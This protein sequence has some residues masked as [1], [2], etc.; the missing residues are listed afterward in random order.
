MGLFD[1]F[2]YTNVHELNLDWVLSMMKALEAEWEAFTAGNSLT[3][4]DPMLH[5]ITKTY[6]KNTIVLDNN[7]NAYVSLQPV[8]VGVALGNQDY[9]LMVFDYEAFI[10][11]VNKNFTAKY[12]RGQYR[13]TAAMAIGDWLTVDDVLC[14]ATAA[15]AADDVL[16]VGVNIEHFTLEDFIKAFMTSANQMIQQYKNDIDASELAYRNQLA[17]DI[18]NT[19]ASLQAQ[20]DAAISG[21]TVDSE[22]INARVGNDH[23]TYPTLGDAIRTQINNLQNA[24]INNMIDIVN[25]EGLGVS[26]YAFVIGMYDPTTATINHAYDSRVT[27]TVPISFDHD[28]RLYIPTGFRCY[29]FKIVGGSITPYGSWTGSNTYFTIPANDE[30]YIYIS[31]NPEDTSETADIT[32]WTEGFK[33][34]GFELDFMH[35]VFEICDF[36][37]VENGAWTYGN[38]TTNA[39]RIRLAQYITVSKGDRIIYCVGNLRCAFCYMTSISDNTWTVENVSGV[40]V[41]CPP[42]NGVVVANIRNDTDTAITVADWNGLIINT[43]ALSKLMLNLSKNGK[44]NALVPNIVDGKNLYIY[45]WGGTGNDWCW[46]R[47]P[48]N[49]KHRD[50]AHPHQFVICNHGNGWVMDG[51]PQ[52]ANWTKRTMYVPLTDPDYINDPT[53]YNGT[54]DSSLWYSNPTIEKLLEYGYV[55]C[56]CENYGDGLYGN[57]NCRNACVGFF[58]HMTEYY[59]VYKRC[60][61]IGSSNGGLTSLNAAY[62]MQG[63]VKAMCLLF[64][65]TCLVNQYDFNSGM[66]AEIRSAYGIADPDITLDDLAKAVATHDPLTVDV[67]D[68]VKVGVMPPTKLWY[69]PDD[70]V[71]DCDYNTLPFAALLDDSNKVVETVQASGEHGDHTHFDPDAILAWFKAN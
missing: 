52:K 10:E 70:V 48:A 26:S 14:K 61:M 65:I 71:V 36:Q 63:A 19:T 29:P 2:P 22:V 39:N 41:Y 28:V 21:V 51:T 15:I 33:I 59:N 57:N 12:Y 37:K 44:A 25:C 53:E 58:E 23:V 6:A 1:H 17:Q 47:T 5:D 34:S 4:A 38:K 55:V 60:Y 11:K 32:T 3:F 16:E 9:W 42:D 8:P 54:A 62:L 35:D 7:G 45:H 68:G 66:R 18:A 31:R 40:G 24:D 13:A 46:V 50:C 27:N 56:G 43:S 20:L 64:P 49:Y 69:S 30:C 67:V